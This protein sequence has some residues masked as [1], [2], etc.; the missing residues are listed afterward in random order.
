MVS[1]PVAEASPAAAC[2]I[3][4]QKETD[5]M[6]FFQ[7]KSE[8]SPSPDAATDV[9]VPQEVLDGTDQDFLPDVP[10]L[11]RLQQDRLCRLAGTTEHEFLAIGARLQEFYARTTEIGGISAA[12]TDQLGGEEIREAISELGCIV[13]RMGDFL[14]LLEGEAE[15]SSSTLLETLQMIAGVD[16]PLAGF[17]KIMKILHV[18]G[19]STKIE[20]AR[21]GQLGAGFNN[22]ADDVENLAVQINEKSTRIMGENVSLSCKIRETLARMSDIEAVERE[23][24]RL[25]ID[26]TRSSLEMITGV[27]RKCAEVAAVIAAASGEISRNI[28]QVVT[29]MQFHDITRQQ[30]EHVQEALCDLEHQLTEA[31]AASDRINQSMSSNQDKAAEVYGVCRLQS[32]QL[33]HARDGLT[34]AVS[35]IVGNLQGLADKG[36]G[37]ARQTREMIRV[38]DGAGDS[39]FIEI[40]KGLA[41]VVGLLAKSAAANI[42]LARAVESVAETVGEISSFVVDIETI[43]E[44]IKLIALNSQIKAARTGDEGAA[45]GVL[46]EAIQR[47]SVEACIQTA[48]VTGTLRE[49]TRV[50]EALSGKAAVTSCSGELDAEAMAARLKGLIDA[51][52]IMNDEVMAALAQ[53]DDTVQALTADIESATGGI[54]VHG[55]VDAEVE[56]IT[57]KLAQIMAQACEIAPEAATADLA[58][59]SGRYTMQSERDIHDTFAMAGATA[60]SGPASP[61]WGSSSAVAAGEDDA[62]LGDNIELF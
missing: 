47:L 4:Q 45:L 1:G 12:V 11:L 18:L 35:G 55:A 16:E 32:A 9:H 44:E 24:V 56:S 29:S 23:N 60:L 10:A 50:T 3:R 22:L 14:N 59:L 41:P 37:I 62:E 48:A 39:L 26:K 13:D 51:I 34:A 58:A 61:A 31:H 38:A 30:L 46:A 57:A 19:I 17:K 6:L 2:K 20:S 5:Y 53:S 28:S 25:V 8:M 54:T 7:R 52:R 33:L 15:Q 27:H 40:E 36:R 49:I 42:N 21:L 43:G